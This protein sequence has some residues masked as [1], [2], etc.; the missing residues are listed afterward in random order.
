M[1]IPEA[2]PNSINLSFVEGLYSDFKRD[3]ASVSPEWRQYFAQ[4]ENGDAG[5]EVKL[6]PSFRP[7]SLFHAGNRTISKPS[8]CS[9]WSS[10]AP[11]V[12]AAT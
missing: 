10:S 7:R 12:C 6:E 8:A 1:K 2:L 5:A 11:T 9:I 4:M 3:A